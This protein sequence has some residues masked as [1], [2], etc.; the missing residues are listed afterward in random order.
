MQET[1][2]GSWVLKTLWRMKWQPSPVLWAQNHLHTHTHTH[3]MYVAVVLV[4]KSCL[5]LC[6]PMDYS[7]PFSSVHGINQ[8]RILEWVAI[9]FSRVS[10]RPRDWTCVS[11]VSCIAGGFFTHWTTGKTLFFYMQ[12]SSFPSTTYWRVCLFSIAYS[13][14]L[15]HTLV[16]HW[17][18]SLCLDILSIL[19]VIVCICQRQISWGMP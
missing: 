11:C 1:W 6:H 3:I 4:T 13:C 18:V 5:T 10:S 16:D 19:N 12:L 8:A 9:S 14:L 17:C 2:V 15:C 7:S